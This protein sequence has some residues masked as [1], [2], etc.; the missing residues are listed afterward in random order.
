MG[1]RKLLPINAHG[2]VI[3]YENPYQTH[4]TIHYHTPQIKLNSWSINNMRN[5]LNPKS[6][7]SCKKFTR[8][9]PRQPI[10]LT[11]KTYASNIATC[12]DTNFVCIGSRQFWSWVCQTWLRRSSN[13]C[14]GNVLWKNHNR[15]GRKVILR[16]N[17]EM[18]LFKKVCSHLNIRTFQR[19]PSKIQ[20]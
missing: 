12:M 3:I 16:N 18:G 1:H 17:H 10:L 7:N 13:E 20:P 9:T 14:I 4:S 19:N 15:L 2:T 11:S 8:R 5:I 6:R